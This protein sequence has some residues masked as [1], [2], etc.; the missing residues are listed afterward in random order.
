MSNKSTIV[1]AHDIRSAHNIGALFRTLEFFGVDQFIISGYSPFPKI[2]SDSRLPHISQK[3]SNQIHKT[4]LG[5]EKIINWKRVDDIVG[6]ISQKR[7]EGFSIVALEQ[8]DYSV[9]LHKF[10]PPNKIL[11][12]L[13]REVQ[14][15][16]KS[17]LKSADIIIEIPALGQKESLN[18]VQAAAVAIYHIKFN[19]IKA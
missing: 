13:G 6:F 1:I 8:S 9:P 12:I 10:K 4:A 2:V 5:S 3:I 16:E 15:I 19:G 7:S 11:L 18:V 17:I 14:G